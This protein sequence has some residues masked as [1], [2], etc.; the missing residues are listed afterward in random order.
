MIRISEG[1]EKIPKR[2]CISCGK[3][4]KYTLEK[5]LYKKSALRFI[6][7]RQKRILH[8]DHG[9]WLSEAEPENY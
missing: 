3:K 4:M 7:N 1:K 2:V 5:L 9:W 6:F 8:I